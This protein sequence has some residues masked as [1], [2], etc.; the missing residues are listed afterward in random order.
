M[1]L[2]VAD[3]VAGANYYVSKTSVVLR[4]AQDGSGAINH[5]LLGDW[6]RY[7]G[8]HHLHEW[9]TSSGAAR[10]ARYAKVRCR[11]D[12]GW[13]LLDDFDAER[14][15][16]VNFVDVG[17]GDGCHIVTPDD[18]I[19]LIDAGISDNME[20]F[21]SWRYNLRARN[22]AGADDYDPAKPDS[23]KWLIHHVVMSHPDEDHYGGL[24]YVFA[25]PKL[26]FARF[27]HN[28][29]VERP[30]E[31]RVAG[32]EYDW[33][34]GGTF[35]SGGETFLFDRV[36]TKSALQ[37][38]LAAFPTTTK[39]QLAALRKLFANSPAC[40]AEAV[41]VSIDQL[42]TAA[43]LP[44]FEPGKPLSLQILGPI[45]EARDFAGQ[46]RAAL[47]VLG[48][49][50]VTKNGHSVIFRGR[51]GK[52]RLFLG[53]DL[54]EQAQ[55]FLL[56]SYAGSLHRPSQLAEAIASLRA[57]GAPLAAAD[58]ARL[59]ALEA[60]AAAMAAKG[61][62]VFGAD[63]AKACHHGS[64]HVLDE[65]IVATDAVAT[66][67]SSGDE[68]SHSH[69]R[70][71]ALG[72]YGKWG[73]GRRPLI[74]STELARSS[75]EFSPMVESHLA[76]RAL[77][78]EIE[79]EPDPEA[80]QALIKALE[81]KKD[82]QVAVY[83]MITLRALGDRVIIAQKLEKPRKPSQ[84]WDIYELEWDAVEGQFAYHPH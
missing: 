5:L 23:G 11:G 7:L 64:Q 35:D 12:T 2:S 78:M 80:K 26:A 27:Y 50:G 59:A 53:G 63:V 22:V 47:R 79:D 24:A 19:L 61:R 72:A 14:A 66:V 28:G 49:E 45:H 1:P 44:G 75:P 73:R 8:E 32:V 20:R 62:E 60:E 37:S 41:G 36:A 42:D 68:E 39:R 83:G 21:L 34:L 56:Q 30:P 38:L 65:F 31:P 9:T 51:Y 82:R 54:N 16:E 55:N 46:P 10:S 29:I 67:L 43:F 74:F 48:D 76:M 52:L 13:L 17:Q 40:D 84:K 3:L 18:E 58:T 6:L 4:K 25:N 70:P 69:P 33:D 71:D 57:T 15:L 77:I 81:A